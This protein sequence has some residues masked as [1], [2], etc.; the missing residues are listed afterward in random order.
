MCI[1]LRANVCHVKA[2]ICYD[3]VLVK[4]ERSLFYQRGFL[5]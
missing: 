5:E 3:C 2:I 1:T 4:S